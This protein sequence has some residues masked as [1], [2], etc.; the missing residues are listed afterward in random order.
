MQFYGDEPWVLAVGGSQG[1]VAIWDT[2][3]S[4]IV[5]N[6]FSEE[7]KP[8]LSNAYKPGTKKGKDGEV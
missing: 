3:E 5:R 8:Y 7:A 1:E 4:E 2:E 6:H